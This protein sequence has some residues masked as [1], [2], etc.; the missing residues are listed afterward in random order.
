MC[1]L[2]FSHQPQ[3]EYPLVVAANRDE[4]YARATAPAQFWPEHPQ[5][6]AGKDLQLG[7]TWM[8]ITRA[9]RF[10]AIT[11]CRGGGDD[12]AKPAPRSRGELPL[13]FLL[14]SDSP[15]VYLEGVAQHAE[16]YAGFNLLAG[17]GE[18]L[19]FFTNRPERQ[20]SAL[21]EASDTANNSPRCLAP[22]IYGLSNAS[23]DTAW[24][25]VKLGKQALH[26]LLG[27]ED[28]SH[29]ALAQVVSD[30]QHANTDELPDTG[31]PQ[32]FN[33]A[34]SA[35]FVQTDLYGTRSTTTAWCDGQGGWHWREHSFD[36]EGA[37][38]NAMTE[39]FVRHANGA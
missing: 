28:L 38:V 26:K 14:G 25:K 8:G 34:L 21:S 23:L 32:P 22:G 27:E 35:Q 10:A 30:R 9:G 4:Y 33:R 12:S 3:T 6:L 7:G 15:Q 39:R 17:E 19:W 5:L 18:E 1:L 37:L 13:N 16:H 11:N 2:I 36:A 24:P 29:D 31:L 20:D